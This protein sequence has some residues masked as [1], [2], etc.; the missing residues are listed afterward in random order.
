MASNTDIVLNIDIVSK[1][2]EKLNVK[3]IPKVLDALYDHYGVDLDYIISTECRKRLADRGIICA[4]Y[5]E[6]P[7]MLEQLGVS[8]YFPENHFHTDGLIYIEEEYESSSSNSERL[9][10]EFELDGFN[11]EYDPSYY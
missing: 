5:V 11:D 8:S 7:E 6:I 2:V 3:D 1:I 9:A 4:S 10:L